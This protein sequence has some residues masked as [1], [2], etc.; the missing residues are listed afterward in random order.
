M[1]KNTLLNPATYWPMSV[2]ISCLENSGS[3]I[4]LI[5]P[6]TKQG[7]IDGFLCSRHGSKFWEQSSE[8]YIPSAYLANNSLLPEFGVHFFHAN[9]HLIFLSRSCIFLTSR[10]VQLLNSA[11]SKSWHTRSHWYTQ[12]TYT[13]KGKTGFYTER[14][15][16][17]LAWVIWLSRKV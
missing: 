8:Q 4:S 9:L 2:K 6:F 14:E 1:C 15:T 7:F 17:H 3:S 5:N 13:K 10:S 16:D 11:W 12:H